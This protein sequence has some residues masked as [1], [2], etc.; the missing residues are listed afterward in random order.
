MFSRVSAFKIRGS[1]GFARK[2]FKG[3]Q[4]LGQTKFKGSQG[5]HIKNRGFQGYFPELKIHRLF[6]K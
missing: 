2:N 4:G 1:Q 3:S 5:Y 6:F